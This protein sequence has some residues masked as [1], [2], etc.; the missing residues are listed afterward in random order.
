[1]TPQ[2]LW[3][4]GLLH[5]QLPC[6]TS[7]MPTLPLPADVTRAATTHPNQ[8]TPS[9]QPLAPPPSVSP[10]AALPQATAAPGVIEGLASQPSQHL[11]KSEAGRLPPKQSDANTNVEALGPKIARPDNQQKAPTADTTAPS[12]SEAAATSNASN[13]RGTLQALQMLFPQELQHTLTAPADAPDSDG[14]RHVKA[15]I[16]IDNVSSQSMTTET[17]IQVVFHIDRAL[18]WVVIC[19]C[20]CWPMLTLAWL[21]LRT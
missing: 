12:T 7:A 8:L 11:P 15:A 17:G 4:D 16:A 14:N 6:T 5:L 20:G 9:Q 10:T 18:M 19:F 3:T 2:L 13:Q 1:M 21:M